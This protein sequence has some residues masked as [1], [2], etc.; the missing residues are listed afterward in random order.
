MD[1]SDR[2]NNSLHTV[3]GVICARRNYTHVKAPQKDTID[4]LNVLVVTAKYR[5][6]RSQVIENI[7]FVWINYNYTKMIS[8]IGKGEIQ[9]YTLDFKE[10]DHII[11][12][13]D[14]V[15]FPAID[16]MNNQC[17]YSEVL[18]YE[19]TAFDKMN[20]VLVPKYRIC[21]RNEIKEIEAKYGNKNTF[22]K[23]IAKIDPIARFMDFRPGD[24]L[25]ITKKSKSLRYRLVTLNED[26]I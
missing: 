13:A 9:K 21:S 4:K 24:V 17:Y 19:E 23:M 11:F 22:P 18:T 12:I 20:H 3:T 5:N 10:N 26:M 14:S 1:F 25:E 2:M 6:H 15:S 8:S 16:Y 7:Y